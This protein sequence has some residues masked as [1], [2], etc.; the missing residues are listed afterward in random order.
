M[1]FTCNFCTELFSD[2]LTYKGH[3]RKQHNVEKRIIVKEIL[4]EK[5]CISCVE[6]CNLNV[7]NV[8]T[9]KKPRFVQR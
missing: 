8:L 5:G 3:L 2:F 1:K 4:L 6:S 9:S 7:L